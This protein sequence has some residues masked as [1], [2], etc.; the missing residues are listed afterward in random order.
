[1]SKAEILTQIA[2]EK[3]Y[4]DYCKR[5]GGRDYMDLYQHVFEIMAEQTEEKLIELENTNKIGVFYACIAYRNFNSKTSTFYNI[6][7]RSSDKIAEIDKRDLINTSDKTPPITYLNKKLKEYAD[8]SEKNWYDINIFNI[9][10]ELGTLRAV[11][12]KTGIHFTSLRY[13]LK[14]VKKEL[15]KI[16]AEYY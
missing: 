2:N 1:M 8:K 7:K 15:K 6:Y 14:K 12:E 5:V 13:S 16:C 11:E 4:I 9:Y 10:V 3:K